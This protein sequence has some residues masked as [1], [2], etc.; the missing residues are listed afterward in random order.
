MTEVAQILHLY[1]Y[2]VCST[3]V[4]ILKKNIKIHLTV[5]ILDIDKLIEIRVQYD[6]HKYYKLCRRNLPGYTM[7]IAVVF[8]AQAEKNSCYDIQKKTS[9]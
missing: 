4:G 8:S 3:V 9:Q 6:F 1:Y 7:L 2:D 5:F